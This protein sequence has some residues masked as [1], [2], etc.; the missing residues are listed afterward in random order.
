MSQSLLQN[1]Y[2]KRVI[3]KHKCCVGPYARQSTPS[4][5]PD[6][7]AVIPYVQNVS[8]AIRRVLAP[9][10]I[11]T[12]FKPH[13]TLRSLL[14]HVKDPIPP[15]GRKGV[16]YQISCSDCPATHVGQTGRTLEHRIKEHKYALTSGN[17]DKSAVAEHMA[18]TGHTIKWEEARVIDVESELHQRCILESWHIHCQLNAINRE[19]GQ[20][21]QVYHQLSG[22][23]Q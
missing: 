8:E 5:S 13:R 18:T 20:L 3:S 16:V 14:V 11:R 1:G 7:Y 17:V 23:G 12:C 19:Q 4:P 10:N 21:P 2:P 22:T 9:L 6:S 15:E